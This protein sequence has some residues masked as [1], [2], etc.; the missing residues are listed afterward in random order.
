M[1]PGKMSVKTIIGATLLFWAVPAAYVLAA[2]QV[3]VGK[4]STAG[5]V[6]AGTTFGYTLSVKNQGDETAQNVVVT[7]T[8]NGNLRV[9]GSGG[10]ATVSTLADGRQ[11]ITWNLG[12]LDPATAT[13]TL[14]FSAATSVN[15]PATQSIS[16]QATAVASNSGTTSSNLVSVVVTQPN[17]I[18]VIVKSPNASQI[19]AAGTL[20][21][22]IT[23]TNT[24]GM[25]AND[26][27]LTDDI[28]DK[29]TYLSA[30]PAPTTMSVVGIVPISRL[31]WMMGSMAPGASYSIT[32]N[33]AADADLKVGDQLFNSINVD[34]SNTPTF[35]STASSL[36][37]GLAQ[38]GGFALTTP[39]PV[40]DPLGGVG[41][42]EDLG[43]VAGAST[44]PVTGV[45]S[46]L[47]LLLV[48]LVGGAYAWLGT[49]IC[50]FES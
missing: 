14:N 17:P 13:S 40:I 34:G 45:D 46:A 16:N 21:Y 5:T 3:F 4:T 41:G 30:S 36:V 9:A 8:L 32:L 33:V 10:P 27:V 1:K 2:P 47:L 44:L 11:V 42:P 49:K 48:F 19:S 31:R 35:T 22:T 28:G 24:G 43:I 15:L 50:A 29:M 18:V 37:A 6:P 38:G 20:S 12:S 39:P 26:V 7:D 25:T 23:A